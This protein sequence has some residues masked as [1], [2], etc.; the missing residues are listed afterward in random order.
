MK[1]LK[2]FFL[3]YFEE[4]QW[5]K[6]LDLVQDLLTRSIFNKIAIIAL[7]F[8]LL[9]FSVHFFMN[10]EKKYVFR[11]MSILCYVIFLITAMVL[12]RPSGERVFIIWTLDMFYSGK[13]FH[14][15]SIMLAIIKMMIFIPL[16]FIVFF[17]FYKSGGWKKS[18]VFVV[19]VP[20][21]LEMCK[22]VL[23]KGVPSLGGISVHIIG[24]MIG[25]FI[26]YCL[27]TIRH[28]AAG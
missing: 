9:T 10:K 12:G 7:L 24:G 26:S 13:V 20:V 28:L 23:A 3:L 4:R 15:T 8:S 25:Y 5:F 21:I 19:I 1:V 11:K 16:G 14:E 17:F 2:R 22:F 27:L 6:L 18:V